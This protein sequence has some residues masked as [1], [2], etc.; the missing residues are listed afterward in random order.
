MAGI[1]PWLAAVLALLPVAACGF[2]AGLHG[3][4][5]ERLIAVEF[6]AAVTVAILVLM[7]F[8]FDQPSTIDLALALSLLSLPATLLLA[9]FIERWL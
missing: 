2:A 5:A 7:S 1:S 4:V 6:A 8:A 9:H 3:D